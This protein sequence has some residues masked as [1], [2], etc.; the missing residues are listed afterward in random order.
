MSFYLIYI[1]DYGNTGGRLDDP[2]QPIFNLQAAFVPVDDGGWMLVEQQLVELIDEINRTLKV[3]KSVRLHMAEIYQR[4]GAFRKIDV[5]QAFD[6]IERVLDIAQEGNVRYLP[7]IEYKPLLLQQLKNMELS[8]VFDEKG[9]FRTHLYRYSFPTLLGSIDEAL[10]DLD[11]Y[12]MLFLD[13]QKEHEVLSRMSYYKVARGAGHLKRII[14]NPIFCDNR[15]HTLL[16]LADF[17]GYIFT[18]CIRDRLRASASPKL[19]EW[20]DKFIAPSLLRQTREPKAV[21]T[22]DLTSTIYNVFAFNIELEEQGPY[23][24]TFMTARSLAKDFS[25]EAVYRVEDEDPNV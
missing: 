17:S 15:V 10:E 24:D 18:G 7:T 20:N 12:G 13:Q 4:T 14:E 8:T 6:W 5:S 11:A 16:S 19:S 25:L 23:E 3:T 9:R 1:D 2:L 21:T 22:A